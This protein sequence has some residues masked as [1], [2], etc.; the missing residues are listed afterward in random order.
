MVNVRWTGKSG[1][2]SICPLCGAGGTKRHLLEMSLHG[3]LQEI[4]DSA[5]INVL[6]CPACELR[7]CE[8]L[9]SVDYSEAD[10][11]GLRFYLDQGA[12]IDVM[13]E[14]LSLIDGRPVRRYLEIGCSFGF[15]M[16]Y[17]RSVLGWEVQGFDPGVI[18]ALGKKTLGL[19]IE[20]A[21]FDA[22]DDR[23]R[24]IDLVYCS[25]V[26]E[27]IPDP[28]K[29][30]ALVRKAL[31]PDGMLL[32]TTPNGDALSAEAGREVF[33]PILS[34][35]HHLLIYNARSIETLLRQS[36]FRDIRIVEN[37]S[38]LRIAASFVPFRGESNYFSRALYRRYLETALAKHGADSPV[39][40]GFLYRLLKE[41]VNR[42]CYGEAS[43]PYDKLRRI[44]E[45]RYGVDI[46][47]P[48]T[49]DFPPFR[50]VGLV[51]FGRRWPYNLCGVWY[52][53]G[54]AQ[55]LG[56]A[57]PGKA[58]ETFDAAF[59]FGNALR[60]CLVAVGT[61]DVE[62]ANLCR[63]AELAGLA[64]LAQV[65]PGKA[66][67]AFRQLLENRGDLHPAILAAHA[68]R[69][70][71]RLFTDFVNLGDYVAA[72]QLIDANEAPFCGPLD[73]EDLPVG[74]A[75]G[76]YQLNH[77][78]DF[79]GA[80]T[81]FSQVSDIAYTNPLGRAFY[82][83]GRFHHGLACKYLGDRATAVAVAAELS[84]PSPDLP[85]VPEAYARR[86]AELTG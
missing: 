28:H 53:R 14:P 39:S 70:R 41:L 7:Y 68:A 10:Q 83:H 36:G 27:H 56:E 77:R 4:L 65:A 73:A 37:V 22:T 13:L 8:P 40:V 29:F 44:Y 24:D 75:W 11:E 9:R 67:E 82:W 42:G 33:L 64:A 52:F 59:R 84:N 43:G 15:V 50:G 20:N 6:Q 35:G 47:A 72:E 23:Q 81:V 74:L 60:A 16:D 51:E 71:K 76:V 19:P 5:W 17:A 25:E 69:A 45:A 34:P 3:G 26:I 80:C 32:M 85:A 18:A 38:Q 57:S 1:W 66:L 78:S 46:D 55:F 48:G 86:I 58:A 2:A 12:G 62:T 61:E 49:F 21:Y 30:M 63:E 31:R 54:V 79:A